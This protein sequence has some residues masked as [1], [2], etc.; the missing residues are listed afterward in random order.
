MREIYCTEKGIKRTTVEQGL[1]VPHS[2]VHSTGN[3]FSGMSLLGYLK[4]RK[5]DKLLCPIIASH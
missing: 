1:G 2:S 4:A 3:S 5:V